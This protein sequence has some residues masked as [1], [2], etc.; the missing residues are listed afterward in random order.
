MSWSGIFLVFVVSHLVGDFLFQTGWQAQNKFGALGG[1]GK[2]CASYL[3]AFVPATVWLWV[4]GRPGAWSIGLAAL[5]VVPHVLQDD[6]RL[7]IRYIRFVKR[8]QA[9]PG[10]RLFVMVDQSFHILALFGV[11]LLA[12]A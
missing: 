12:I 5:I 2:P 4:D 1:G 8:S 11:A 6:G 7:L 9:T 10:D 3:V